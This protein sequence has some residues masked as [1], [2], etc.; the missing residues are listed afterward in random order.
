[1]TSLLHKS[2]IKSEIYVY[3]YKIYICSTMNCGGSLFFCGKNCCDNSVLPHVDSRVLETQ[4][5]KRHDD[6][7]SFDVVRYQQNFIF[8]TM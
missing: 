3:E 4:N 8:D 2:R 6:F 7:R 5:I 1:M